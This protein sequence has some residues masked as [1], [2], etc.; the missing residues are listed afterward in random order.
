[1]RRLMLA[2]GW[3][4]VAS[5]V[6]SAQTGG[7]ITGEVR[8]TSGATIPNASITV[9]NA[10]TNASRSTLT[11]TAGLYSF[12]D[13]TPGMYNV[14]AGMAGFDTVIKSN[15]ELQVQQVVRVDFALAVGQATQSIE[16]SA[17]G[18]LLSTENAT[19]GTVIDGARIVQM[20]LNG[21]N[22][23]SL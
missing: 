23:L 4:C 16:V 19:V 12:P 21:R 22:Y 15:I 18:A 2:V 1:M 9:T 14:K 5:G 6:V 10:A 11:N 20:P 13:L 17:N 3:L 8:D 7:Q